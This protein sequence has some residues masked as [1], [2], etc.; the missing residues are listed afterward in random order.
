[1]L[2][3][4]IQAYLYLLPLFL[5]AVAITALLKLPAQLIILHIEKTAIY[6]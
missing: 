5:S 3:T 6:Y 2:N 4:F 1:M